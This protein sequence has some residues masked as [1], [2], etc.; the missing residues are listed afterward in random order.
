MNTEDIDLMDRVIAALLGQKLYKTTQG[1][2]CRSARPVQVVN[3]GEKVHFSRGSKTF[4]SGGFS[5]GH[6]VDGPHEVGEVEAKNTDFIRVE[7]TAYTLHAFSV[8]SWHY[9]DDVGGGR[10]RYGVVVCLGEDELRELED[11]IIARRLPPWWSPELNDMCKYATHR[12]RLAAE[13][14][15]LEGRT[16]QCEM[17]L[18]E[19]Q[20]EQRRMR[21][22]AERKARQYAGD[23]ATAK[24]I[25]H[26]FY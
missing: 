9:G 5:A 8:A 25:A 15:Q 19:R 2:L 4:G 11:E 3:P 22:E 14:K 24:S 1:V 21:E 13:K 16:F 6:R 23:E 20:R 26:L 17:E 10:W 18:K 12:I 7:T